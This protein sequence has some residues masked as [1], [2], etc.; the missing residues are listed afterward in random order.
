[1]VRRDTP[2]CGGYEQGVPRVIPACSEAARTVPATGLFDALGKE[3]QAARSSGRQGSPETRIG[4]HQ[5]DFSGAFLEPH[6]DIHDAVVATVMADLGRYVF[7]RGV[8]YELDQGPVDNA[9]DR[10]GAK[11]AVQGQHIDAHI[12]AIDVTLG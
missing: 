5:E 12:H 9:L 1:G 10:E 8:R 2:P 6:I 11:P 3:V 4:F 7:H